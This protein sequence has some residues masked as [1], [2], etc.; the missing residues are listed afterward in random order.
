MHFNYGANQVAKE[1]FINIPAPGEPW[2]IPGEPVPRA[3]PNRSL[4]LAVRTPKASLV[5]EKREAGSRARVVWQGLRL[6]RNP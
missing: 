2:L 3:N 6:R 4:F 5:G 1:F